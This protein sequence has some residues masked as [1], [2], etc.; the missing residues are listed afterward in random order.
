MTENAETEPAPSPR[1]KPSRSNRVVLFYAG[2]VACGFLLGRGGFIPVGFVG[3]TES[4]TP[5]ARVGF[6]LQKDGLPSDAT[7]F[8]TLRRDLEVAAAHFPAERRAEFD[9]VVAVRGLASRGE[10][11][12]SRAASL[13][14]TLGWP[15]CDR[16]SL[17]ELARRSRP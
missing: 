13:C 14:Q 10:P 2:A 17:E 7:A 4:M 5:L 11:D 9:L 8:E 1:P 3:T 16:A 15:R 12:W 6:A